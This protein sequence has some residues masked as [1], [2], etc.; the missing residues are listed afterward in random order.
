MERVFPRKVHWDDLDKKNAEHAVSKVKA[1]AETL[2][3]T[4]TRSR[5]AAK[6]ALKKKGDGRQQKL[7]QEV[8][9]RARRD[10]RSG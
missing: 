1:N 9:E 10:Q 7:P 4:L 2:L 5:V 8:G 3:S 6:A